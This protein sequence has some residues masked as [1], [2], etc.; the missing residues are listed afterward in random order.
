MGFR[1]DEERPAVAFD[2]ASQARWSRGSAAAPRGATAAGGELQLEPAQQRELARSRTGDSSTWK[3]A[4]S[5]RPSA[6]PAQ[7]SSTRSGRSSSLRSRRPHCAREMPAARAAASWLSPG[8]EP[9]RSQLV[10]R[11][12]RTGDGRPPVRGQ[13]AAAEQ[14]SG[15]P[16]SRALHCAVHADLRATRRGIGRDTVG[17]VETLDDRVQALIGESGATSVAVVAHRPLHGDRPSLEIDPDRVFHAASTMKVPVLVELERR[18]AAGELGLDDT[19]VVHNAFRSLAD[20]S[21][22]VL[23]PADDSELALYEREGEAV[24]LRELVL[25]AITESS[26]LATNLLVDRLGAERINATMAAL[27]AP[28]LVVRRGVE[29]DAAW[30][31]GLNNTV[32]AAG[33]ATL[34]L[35][36]ARRRGSC[37]R[38]RPTRCSRSSAPRRSTR[39]SRPASRRASSSP[40]RPARSRTCT[41]TP[42]SWRRRAQCRTCSWC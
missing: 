4:P 30:R 10:A 29:D 32:T 1:F 13:L 20:G 3:R 21:P 8:R 15:Q 2:I 28:S 16:G 27:G 6:R 37:R 17:E 36:M 24:T 18:A 42:R 39:G 7:H 25:L 12:M 19:L 22:Y 26:N 38:R 31:A 34:L 40:T 33:L 35:A 41:T 5:C 23:D 11:T 9:R 14:A